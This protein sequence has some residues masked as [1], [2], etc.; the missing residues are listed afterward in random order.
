MKRRKYTHNYATTKNAEIT[1]NITTP[2]TPLIPFRLLIKI[3]HLITDLIRT[4]VI[5]FS[6][7]HELFMRNLKYLL[8]HGTSK[9]MFYAFCCKKNLTSTM[10][11]ASF[12]M[13]HFLFL[14]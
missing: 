5:H 6:K 3:I 1:D 12:K 10:N 4:Y 11:G 9:T 14:G 13:P 2:I 7:K 8:F